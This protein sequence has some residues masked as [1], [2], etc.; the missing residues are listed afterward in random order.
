M[1]GQHQHLFYEHGVGTPPR[2]TAFFP[3]GDGT[4]HGN[5]LGNRSSSVTSSSCSSFSAASSSARYG[6][7]GD[8]QRRGLEHQR[9]RSHSPLQLS[10]RMRM[11]HYNQAGTK[12]SSFSA[13]PPVK[14][15]SFADPMA[16]QFESIM[17]R[18][19]KL[20]LHQKISSLEKQTQETGLR[21]A[22]LLKKVGKQVRGA[23]GALGEVE[24][25]RDDI[26]QALMSG[27]SSAAAARKLGQNVAEKNDLAADKISLLYKDL[28]SLRAKVRRDLEVEP[29][30]GGTEDQFM[31]LIDPEPGSATG[32]VAAAAA[33][34]PAAG[35]AGQGQPLTSSGCECDPSSQLS[36]GVHQG[37]P[38]TWC[39]VKSSPDCRVLMPDVKDPGGWDHALYA[40]GGENHHQL[41]PTVGAWD[42]CR[43]SGLEPDHTAH[44]G[45]RCG[46]NSTLLKEYD[47]LRDPHTGEFSEASFKKIPLRDRYAVMLMARMEKRNSREPLA[48]ADLCTALEHDGKT[49]FFACPTNPRCLEKSAWDGT[50]SWFS[51]SRHNWDFCVPPSAAETAAGYEDMP[52]AKAGA[53]GGSSSTAAAAGGG[54]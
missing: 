22:G 34:A 33:A 14:A 40:Y 11:R 24:D 13:A 48:G 41:R 52:G 49:Q 38:F 3:A 12:M 39:K 43:P 36:C 16:E 20:A 4:E 26:T 45:C 47:H 21:F 19:Q 2:P 18:V 25:M 44:F 31:K 46:W 9:V 32:V 29:S 53:V 50:S 30:S 28:T 7:D 51:V 42:Y 5:L 10:G 6:D 1:Q 17:T 8:S 23:V 27:S 15:T 35:A 37:T 54:N